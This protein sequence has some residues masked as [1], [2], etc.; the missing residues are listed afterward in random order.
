[1]FSSTAKEKN[2]FSVSKRLKKSVSIE[3][4]AHNGSLLKRGCQLFSSSAPKN[5]TLSSVCCNPL[6]YV[7][8][9]ANTKSATILGSKPS[10][11]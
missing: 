11:L 5:I 10:I 6:A 8:M 3:T 1:M 4:A 9:A 7:L 2:V